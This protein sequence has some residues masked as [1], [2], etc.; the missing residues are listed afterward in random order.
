MEEGTY[1]AVYRGEILIKGNPNKLATHEYDPEGLFAVKRQKYNFQIFDDLSFDKIR[2]E[3]EIHAMVH[4]NDFILD[5]HCV[6]LTL[7]NTELMQI[8]A[9]GYAMMV[10]TLCEMDLQNYCTRYKKPYEEL[11]WKIVQY[12]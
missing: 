5:L 8:D 3:L 11:N 10:M 9:D 1:G 4:S 6:S 12:S 2:N 7:D